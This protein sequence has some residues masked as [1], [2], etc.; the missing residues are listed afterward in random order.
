MKPNMNAVSLAILLAALFA[1]PSC[2]KEKEHSHD[3]AEAEHHSDDKPAGDAHAE[4]GHEHG[5]AHTDEVKLTAGAVRDAGIRMEP[6][7]KRLLSPVIAAPAQLA[8]NA[9][10][11]A[12]VGAPTMGR[13]V[14]IEAR[15]GDVVKKGDTLLVIE[16]SELGQAQSE[17]LQKR[18]DLGIALAAVEPAKQAS[19]RA[20]KLFEQSQGVSLGEVQKREAETRAAEGAAMAAN[21]AS[22]AAA[23]KLLLLGMSEADV[24][25]LEDKGTLNPRLPI[26]A[27]LDGSVI[28]REVTLGELVSP[29]KEALLVMADTS[30]VWLVAEVPGAKLDEIAVGDTATIHVTAAK[31][32]KPREGKVSYISPSL[33]PTTRTARV[34]IE[35]PNPDAKLRPGTFARAEI[36]TTPAPGT[37]TETLAILAEAVQTVEGGPAVFVPVEG[38]ENTFAKR[39]VSVGEPVDGWVPVLSGLKEGEPVVVSGTFV[40]K[41]DLGKSSAAH[42]H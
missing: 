29:E 21:A 18:T 5:E 36:R 13:V 12:H 31:E 22:H 40:L 37:T 20:R 27:P 14:G 39:T 32:E 8:F 6:V 25:T 26:R 30:T 24:K 42:E 11:M 28:E 15:V 10:A 4:H 17:H 23:N 2:A 9:E 1:V 35:L 3:A 33:D 16:S 19:D 41:A 7:A 34:R 38:E